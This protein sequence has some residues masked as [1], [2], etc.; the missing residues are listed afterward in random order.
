MIGLTVQN[1]IIKKQL[2][3]VLLAGL[4]IAPLSIYLYLT[5]Y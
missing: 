1:I 4:L 5:G 3:F 2:N